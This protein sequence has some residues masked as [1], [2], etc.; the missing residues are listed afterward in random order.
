MRLGIVIFPT[1]TTLD[2]VALGKAVEERGF[3]SLWF[4]EH[5]HLPLRRSTPWGGVEGRPELPEKYWRTYDGYVAMAAIAASTTSLRV[6][7]AITLVAQRDPVW[8]AKQVASLD[9]ISGG[10]FEFGVGFG[11][12]REE[13]EGHGTDPRTRF[14][15]VGESLALMKSLWEDD[16]ASYEGEIVSLEPSKAWPKPVQSPHPPITLGTSA[17]PKGLGVLFDHA[18]G[19]MPFGRNLAGSIDT[20]RGEADRRGVDPD[21]WAIT[22]YDVGPSLERLEAA[23]AIGARRALFHIEEKPAGEVLDE[24]DQLADLKSRFEG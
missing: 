10:R 22:I 5:S 9:R 6:G 17:G 2:P 14:E 8:L 16:V 1:D 11:W 3:E 12:N 23:A 15:R 20:F 24:L 13:M 19:W 7:S 4:P 18:D 21:D